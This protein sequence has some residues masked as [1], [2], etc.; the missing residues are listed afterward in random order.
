MSDFVVSAGKYVSIDNGHEMEVLF[1]HEA[2]GTSMVQWMD[3]GST[4]TMYTRH[5]QAY[6]EP[7]VNRFTPGE[8]RIGPHAGRAYEVMWADETHAT[9][10]PVEPKPGRDAP[11]VI[12][13]SH[14]QAWK[15]SNE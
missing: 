8:K 9:L 11:F 10:K 6:Y 15:V 13:Q 5:I 12:S 14:S 4:A 1:V 7:K 2:S 3:S